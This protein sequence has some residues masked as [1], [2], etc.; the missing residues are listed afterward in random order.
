MQ[1]L[2]QAVWCVWCSLVSHVM[3]Q[4]IFPTCWLR[5]TVLPVVWY[6]DLTDS[7]TVSLG[8]TVL[9][10]VWYDDL[11]DSQTGSLGWMVLPVVWYDDLT[12]SDWVTGMNGAP[13]CLIWWSYRQSDCVT[14]MNGAPSCLIWW[15]KCLLQTGWLG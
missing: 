10:V 6:D 8:W 3:M 15:C 7:Q 4:S 9:P 13:C 5:W 1:H 14:G 12:E 2:L 11:T